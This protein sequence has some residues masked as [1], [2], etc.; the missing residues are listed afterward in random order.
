VTA[1]AESVFTSSDNLNVCTVYQFSLTS[2]KT[3]QRLIGAGGGRCGGIAADGNTIYLLLPGRKEIRYWSNWDSSS[4][5]GWTFS[6]IDQGGVLTFDSSGRRLLYADVSGTAYALSVPEGKIQSLFSNVGVVHSIATD[7]NHIL[8]ASGKKVLFYSR[9]DNHGENPPSSMQSL[10][11]GLISGVA[12][13]TTDSPW[14][15]DLDKG[16]IEGPFPR[17]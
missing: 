17:D 12:V 14:T 13:D 6:Q 4:S 8:L 2:G 11:G 7:P 15:A 16:L 3:S 5:K 10:S 9:S 1:D